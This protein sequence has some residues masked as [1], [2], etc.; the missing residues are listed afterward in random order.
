[1]KRLETILRAGVALTAV[2]AGSSAV[3]AAQ[4]VVPSQ[5]VPVT[6]VSSQEIVITGSRIRRDPLNNNA[7]I[8]FVDKTAIDKTGLSAVG[9]VLQRIPSAAGGLNTKVNASGN[10]GNPP[11]GGGVGAGSATIDLRYLGANRTLVLVDGLRFVNGTSASGIPGSVD[12]NTIPVNMIDRIE[13][14]QAGASPLYG[15]DAIAGVVNVITVQQQRGLRASAQYGQYRP[16]DGKTQDY[17]ASYG[18]QADRTSIVFGASYAKQE[19]IYSRDRS[20]SQFPN[21]YQTTCNI[22]GSG[23]SSAAING[24]FDTRTGNGPQPGINFGNFTISNPPDSTPT[25]AELRPFTNADRFNFAPFQYILTPSKRWGVWVSM[26]SALTDA[27]NLRVRGLYNHRDSENKAAYEPLFIGPDAGNGAGSRFDTLSIDAT[28]PFNPFQTTLESGLNPDGALNG[29]TQTYS[30]IGRRVVEA[31]QRD[32]HQHVDTYSVTGTLDG[33]FHVGAQQWFWDVNSTFGI[34]T[35]RQ[36]FT[37]NLRADR[38]A[39][40][41]G[42]VAACVAPCVPL[43]LFGG[44]GSITQAMLD[45]I[46]FTEHDKSDQHLFDN[47]VNLTGDLVQLPAGPL[48]VAVGYE[49]RYQSASFIPD[50]II[51]AGLGA[52][53]PAHP[54]R[55]HYNVNEVYGEMRVPILKDVPGAYSLELNGAARY[56]HYSTSGG[57]TTYT[58][59]GLWKPVHDLLLRAAYST[60]FRAPTIG[61]LF[62]ARSRYD[63]PVTDPCTSDVSGLFQ[64]NPTV[65]ANC[66]ADGVPADGSYAEQPGQLPVITQGNRNLKPETSKSINL[67]AVYSTTFGGH[68][69]SIEGDYHDIKVKDAISALDPNV[70]L[71]NCA[72][73]AVN[74][75]LTVRTVNGFVN[76]IDATLQNLASIHTR[77]I[78]GNITYRTPLTGIGRF[79]LTA[80]GSW[81]LKYVV[82]Q[83]NGGLGQVV[84]DRRGT[85]R[86][87]PDQAYPNF[88]GN[89]TLDWTY[90]DFNAS[91]TGRYVGK[92][93]EHSLTPPLGQTT[94]DHVLN[95]RVYVDAQANYTLPMMDHRITLT[96]G[97]NNL[98]DKDPPGCFTCSVNNYDPTTYDVPGPFYYGRISYKMGAA[99]AVTPAYVP[100]PP[101]PPPPA[102]VE[103]PAPPPPPPPPPPAPTQ[104]GQRG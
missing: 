77:Q 11:D 79:G 65:K 62:G 36:T 22:G 23:C 38:V 8:V 87:A 56:S 74:C 17:Q 37:G 27:V 96:V 82:T 1:M 80:N 15:S 29:R 33:S 95:S 6:T 94:L 7:P 50:P 47:S 75:N 57:S 89:A 104:K 73:H 67:G 32:F 60:G 71:L 53:I 2:A 86:G 45:W 43:N 64:T 42:P 93:T 69:F 30:F 35:A 66:I 46:T 49:H 51:D 58:V 21:P 52:D 10:L 9:D 40:A 16:G 81:L 19:P 92:V 44:A 41:V 99:R 98:T 91:V 14:L 61:E 68:A 101:P 54:A 12:L 26:K 103:Q 76:E 78:D 28:N 55:G 39:Q 18:I 48:A 13:V 20:I 88:K 34:N 84:I 100:P 90:G 83:T 59:N 72:L 97:G 31:G 3:A 63:L 70:T 4:P 85:E 5:T 25:A 102:V 24:R